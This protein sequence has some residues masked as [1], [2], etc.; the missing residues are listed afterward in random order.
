M[1][2]SLGASQS[3]PSRSLSGLSQSNVAAA[4]LSNPPTFISYGRL[5]FLVMDAPSDSVLHLY[6][7]EMQRYNVCDVVRVCHPTYSTEPLKALG[8]QTHDWPFADG[9]PPPEHIIDDWL[10]LVNGRLDAARS[11]PSRGET[12]GTP[13]PQTGTGKKVEVAISSNAG[14]SDEH[15]DTLQDPALKTIAIHCVAGLGR[16]LQ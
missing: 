8:I 12:T 14:K 16:Y 9:E 13:T 6:I 5:R 11:T 2:N 1:S 4:R 10:N 3:Q 15:H 7:K